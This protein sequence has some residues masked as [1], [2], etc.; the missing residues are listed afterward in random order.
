[1]L[2]AAM[3]DQVRHANS[4]QVVDIDVTSARSRAVWAACHAEGP[5]HAVIDRR[6]ITRASQGV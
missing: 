3:S 1:M 2:G 5:D 6:T 4:T